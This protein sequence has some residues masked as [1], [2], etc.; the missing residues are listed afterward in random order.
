MSIIYT[1]EINALTAPLNRE[2][3]VKQHSNAHVFKSRHHANGVVIAQ[4]AVNGSFQR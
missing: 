1:S 2:I 4:N 3:F